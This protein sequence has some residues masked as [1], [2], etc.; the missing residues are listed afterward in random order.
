MNK[1]QILELA[2]Y[3]FYEGIG[4]DGKEWTGT[5]DSIVEFAKAVQDKLLKK[6]VIQIE[7]LI[8]T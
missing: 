6:I 2:N 5:D 4:E 1:E 3:Y 7:N 8:D